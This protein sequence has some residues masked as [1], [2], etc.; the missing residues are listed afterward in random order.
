[1]S[2]DSLTKELSRLSSSITAYL[3]ENHHA[4]P[5]F[6]AQSALVPETRQYEALRNQLNDVAQD[7]LRLVNGPKNI[8]RTWSWSMTDLSAIQVAL[9]RRFYDLVPTDNI[10]ATA[11]EIAA[12]SGID[13]DRT[14]RVLKMLGTYRIFEEVDGRFRHTAS[15]EFLRTS[16]FTAMA[17]TA[18]DDCFKA[19]SD[20]NIWLER[21][22]CSMGVA[23]SPFH[24]RFDDSFYG[25]YTKNPGKGVRFSKAMIGWSIV[26]DSF[27][28]LR[29]NFKWSSLK[30]TKVIDVGGGNGHASINLAK[31]FPNLNFVVQDISAEQLLTSQA[32]EDLKGRVSLEEYDYFTP[33]PIRDGGVYIYRNT[34]HNHN[35]EDC[36]QMLHSLLPAMEGRDDVTLLINEVIVPERA[37]GDVTRAEENQLRQ[38]DLMMM[39]LFGAKERTE[40]DWLG[41]LK[42]VDQRFEIVNLHYNPTGAGLLEVHLGRGAMTP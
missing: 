42:S 27:P 33:Q 3:D 34:F 29:D 19:T 15:S 36:V 5:D 20:T 16:P 4:Q 13:E 30:N 18:L 21:S 40:K 2:I 41:L 38:L 10:G 32:S 7:L 25:Y 39:A 8:F 17:E 11:K 24:T 37:G 1:M 35:D 22:P 14:S 31:Q 28:V 23:D 6:T 9:S 12:K 26:D